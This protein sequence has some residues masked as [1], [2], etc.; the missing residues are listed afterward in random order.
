MKAVIDALNVVYDEREKRSF[1]KLTLVALAFTFGGLCFVILALGAVV[2]L[3][4]VF[5]WL[6]L[7]SRTAQIISLLRWPALFLIVLVWLA[8]LYRYGPSRTR[9]RWQW[10]SIGSLFA[11]IVWLIG[12]ALFSWYLSNF[13]NYEANYGSLGAGVGLMIWLWI[14][15]IV[16]LV[17]GELN[18]ET[19]HQTVRDTKIAPE[20]PLGQRG[21]VMA[22]TVGEKR[23]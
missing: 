16:V 8:V 20:K 12:S 3:P 21:A 5:A 1:V 23:T 22:D 11:S 18:A 13:A 14:S 6:G 7:E 15:V 10:L 17:G 9:P 19:E 2:I 4:L